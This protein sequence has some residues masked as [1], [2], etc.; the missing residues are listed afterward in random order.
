VPAGGGNR[1]HGSLI[2]DAQKTEIRAALDNYLKPFLV[3]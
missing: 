2:S 3:A 1:Q